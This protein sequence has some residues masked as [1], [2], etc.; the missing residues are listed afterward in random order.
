MYFDGS[1]DAKEKRIKVD[2]GNS[3]KVAKFVRRWSR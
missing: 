2:G 1:N 3:F